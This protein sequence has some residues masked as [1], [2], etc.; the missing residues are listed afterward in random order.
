LALRPGSEIRWR[1]LA[2][3]EKKL[4]VVGYEFLEDRRGNRLPVSIPTAPEGF[5]RRR[6]F[7]WCLTDEA[8]YRL[9]VLRPPVDSREEAERI[10]DELRRKHGWRGRDAKR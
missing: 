6:L 10:A 2:G 8:G 9:P 3:R 7:T 1:A 4:M 5:R